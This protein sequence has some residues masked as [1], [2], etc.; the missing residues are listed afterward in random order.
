MCEGVHFINTRRR[1]T[2]WNEAFIGGKEPYFSTPHV[3]RQGAFIQATNLSLMSQFIAAL[4]KRGG[5]GRRRGKKRE[6]EREKIYESGRAKKVKG[7]RLG[8]YE[9]TKSTEH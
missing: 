7:V 4:V 5:R 8:A 1:N 9:S 2:E 6:E 3:A